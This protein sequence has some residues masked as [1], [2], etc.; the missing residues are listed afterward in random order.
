[1][2]GNSSSGILEMPSFKKITI[3]LGDRQHGRLQA[4][5][6]I[7]LDI[8]SKKITQTIKNFYKGKYNL[9]LK[10]TKNIYSIKNTSGKILQILDKVNFK[11]LSYKKFHDLKR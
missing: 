8:S 7:N 3:N 6:I 4:E 5:S 11:N 10:R 1:M 2:L 9:R